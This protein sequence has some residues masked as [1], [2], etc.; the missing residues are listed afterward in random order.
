M[1]DGQRRAH[2]VERSVTPIRLVLA[3]AAGATG[4][5]LRVGVGRGR[6]RNELARNAGRHVR[7]LQHRDAELRRC[8]PTRPLPFPILFIADVSNNSGLGLEPLPARLR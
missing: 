7:A 3:G 8:T 5:T 2:R 4:R 1:A 6:A